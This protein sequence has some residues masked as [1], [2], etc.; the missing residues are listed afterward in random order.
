MSSK[1]KRIIKNTAFLYI[2]MLFLMLITLFTSRVLLDKLGI[3]DFGIYNVVG[4]LA[5]MFIFFRSSLA[6]ATQRFL[7]VELGKEN[8]KGAQDVFCQHLILYAA[9]S[10]IVII[11]GETAGLWIVLNKLV[12]PADRLH[13]AVWVYQFTLFSLCATLVGIVYNSEVIAHEDMKAFSYIGVFEGVAKLAIAYAISIS[14]FDRLIVYGFM[15]MALTVTVQAFYVFYCVKHYNECKLR[16]IWDKGLLRSTSSVVGWNTV[17]TA[18]YAINDSGVNILLNMFF[19]PA[20]NAARAVSFQVSHA[21]NGFASNFFVSVR[22]QIVKSYASGDNE[23]LLKLFYNSSRFSFFLLWIFCLPLSFSI[24]HV[25]HLWLKEVPEH[26]GIFTVWVLAYSLVNVLNDPVWSV[27][28]ATGKLK[29]YISIGSGVFLLV[30]PIAYIALKSGC[31]PVSVFIILFAV[32]LCYLVV[33]L[34]II[35]RY[36]NYRP[37]DYITKVVKPILSVVSLSVAAVWGIHMALPDT[38][39]FMPLFVILSVAVTAVCIWTAGI[40]GTERENIINFIRKKLNK[41]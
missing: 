6:N 37:S 21:I 9:F 34:H 22:P 25:L 12:I 11:I 20:V 17:G 8:H 29:R 5:V 18:V 32:R 2:R 36:M 19:G 7:N 28:L 24:D 39:P 31:P 30:F 23:Y 35:R 15:L 38:L 16:F 33:V 1:S 27:A 10:L 26:T 3:E 40:S 14:P 41:K 13:A 4:G